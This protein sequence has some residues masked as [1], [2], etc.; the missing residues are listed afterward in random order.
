VVGVAW[1]VWRSKTESKE[2]REIEAEMT[3]AV[4]S[5]AT[6]ESVGSR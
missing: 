5:E 6:L 2:F 1:A 3:G 4:A